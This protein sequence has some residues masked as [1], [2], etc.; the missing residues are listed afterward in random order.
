MLAQGAQETGCGQ[1]VLPGTNN[2]F[3]IENSKGWNGDEYQLNNAL[4]YNEDGTTR[5]ERSK[6]RVYPNIKES[7]DD[8]VNFFI[9]ISGV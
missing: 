2:M 4:E 6:F 3:S 9:K 1:D 7:V 5:H 8:R